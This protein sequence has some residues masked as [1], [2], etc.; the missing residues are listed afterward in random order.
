MSSQWHPHTISRPSTIS[1]NSSQLKAYPPLWCLTMA[2]HLMEMNSKGLLESLTLCTPHHHLISTNPMVSLRPWWRRS[3]MP[4]RKLMDLPML[5]QEHYFSYET[6]LSQQIFLLQ[7][8]YFMDM[9]STRS[10]PFKTLKTDQ[11]MTDSWQRLIEIQNTQKE[12]FDR[13]HRAKDLWSA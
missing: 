1:E 7:L 13:A 10:S 9:T 3:R 12:Q 8:K 11:H 5:K 4:T 2:L 6:H